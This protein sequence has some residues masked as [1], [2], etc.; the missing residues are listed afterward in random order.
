MDREIMAY[1]MLVKYKDLDNLILNINHSIT[2]K[3]INSYYLD[4][5]CGVQKLAS[6][7]IDLMEVKRILYNIKLLIT[8]AI[9]KLDKKQQKVFELRFVKRMK[10]PAIAE[11]LKINKMQAYRLVQSMPKKILPYLEKSS[12]FDEFC[13]TDYYK[14]NYIKS[15]YEHYSEKLH[16][17]IV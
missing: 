15:A 8:R 2:N 7:I 13:N 3:A 17:S 5:Y 1:T 6:N 12:Y 16:K 4:V 10:T 14:I 9:S 11:M